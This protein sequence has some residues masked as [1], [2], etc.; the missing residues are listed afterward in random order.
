MLLKA[1]FSPTLYEY[2]EDEK[3]VV[4]DGKEWSNTQS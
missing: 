3:I 1:T 4:K 2:L